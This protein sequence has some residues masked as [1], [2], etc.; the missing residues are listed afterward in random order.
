M[1][2]SGGAHNQ[3]I[4]I[5]CGIYLQGPTLDFF[6]I[7]IKANELVS[8]V[9]GLQLL[10]QRISRFADPISQFR[11]LMYLKPATWSK[12]LRMESE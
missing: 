8:R 10:A 5:E 6:G 9:E 3:K 2:V 7:L 1:F 12:R 11:A 4:T